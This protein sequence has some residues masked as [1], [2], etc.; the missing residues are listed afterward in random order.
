MI[1]LDSAATSLQKPN[2]VYQS[3]AMALRTMTSP[4]RGNHRATRLAAE[5]A[6]RCREAAAALFSVP[7]P[8]QVVFTFNATHGLNIAVETLLRPGGKVVVSGFE[9]NAVMRPLYA[10]QAS[11][12]V[13]V[14]PQD[15]F[16]VPDYGKFITRETELAVFNHVSNVYGCRQDLDALSDVCKTLGVPL[17]V[18]AS[19]SAGIEPIAFSDLAASFIAMPGHKGLYGPQGT[20][21][22]LCAEPGACLLSGGTGGDSANPHM[23][24]YLPDR[25]EAGTHN[26]PGIAG[27]LAGL[28]YVL[29]KTPEKIAAWE[30]RLMAVFL[31]ELRTI[32][33]ITLYAPKNADRSLVSFTVD[34]MDC[35]EVGDALS[36]RGIAVRTGLHCAPLAHRTGGTFETGTVRVSVSAFNRPGEIII[37][38]SAVREIVRDKLKN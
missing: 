10:R 20:G 26:M 31:R 4:G 23:P 27:L 16:A 35:E 7:E 3:A 22:L 9:H 8:E 25:L 32:P 14:D 34:G 19:Q 33:G 37:A 12:T 1:Y 21:L 18:D 17:I 30:H 11:I 13:A 15:P 28:T 38:A 2:A 29:E 6:Y 36:R 24:D 5:T